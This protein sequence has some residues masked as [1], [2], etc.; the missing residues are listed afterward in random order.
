M[1]DFIVLVD[2]LDVD[3]TSGARAN[4]AFI[5]S[6]SRYYKVTVYHYSRIQVFIDQV[7]LIQIPESKNSLYYFLSRLNRVLRRKTGFDFSRYYEGKFGFSLTFQDDLK[8]FTNI[9]NFISNNCGFK[10]L[11]TLSQGESFLPHFAMLKFP[12]LFNKWVANIHDPFPINYYPPSFAFE[13]LGSDIKTKKMEK[14]FQ[15]SRFIIFPSLM[16]QYWMQEYYKIEP[17]KVRIIPHQICNITNRGNETNEVLKLFDDYDFILLHAGNLLDQR[18]PQ[19]LIS[20]FLSF[21]NEIKLKRRSV[22][23]FFIGPI[24][25]RIFESIRKFQEKEDLYF[26]SNKI[27]FLDSLELQNRASVNIILESDDELSPFLPGKVPHCIAAKK[28]ILLIGP[29]I[30]ETRRLLG[31]NYPFHSLPKNNERIKKLI[32]KLYTEYKGKEY[33]YPGDLHKYFGSDRVTNCF[34][35]L[36]MDNE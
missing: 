14:V 8:N 4:F 7:D 2:D 22:G 36:L 10:I 35:E 5:S 29:N 31:E 23:L 21:K 25:T 13:G 18:D 24:S 26:I 11:L 15:S 6:L 30:S 19:E 1:T 16:L 20:A 3:K 17:N 34:K 9:L 27:S 12:K 32:S 33:N 28:P